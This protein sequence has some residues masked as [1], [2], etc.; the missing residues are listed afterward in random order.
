[1][2]TSPNGSPNETAVSADARLVRNGWLGHR[3]FSQPSARSQTMI[4][5]LAGH[6]S[7]HAVRTPSG[8]LQTRFC[9][10]PSSSTQD[11]GS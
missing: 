8:E 2:T 11:H 1:M 10:S 5:E 9:P 4:A 6:D 3:C 7:T